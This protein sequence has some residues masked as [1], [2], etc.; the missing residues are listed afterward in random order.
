[1]INN[2][3]RSPA[4]SRQDTDTGMAKDRYGDEHRNSTCIASS[5]DVREAAEEPAHPTTRLSRFSSCAVAYHRDL[6]GLTLQ[7]LMPDTAHG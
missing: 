2:W 5:K 1:M 6:C 4:A 7:S 3:P